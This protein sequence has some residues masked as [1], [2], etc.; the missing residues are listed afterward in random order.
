M[1][2]AVRLAKVLI[3]LLLEVLRARSILERWDPF[4]VALGLP[5]VSYAYVAYIVVR[6]DR[7]DRPTSSLDS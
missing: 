1:R 7:P 2:V 6:L 3:R 4:A 5:M